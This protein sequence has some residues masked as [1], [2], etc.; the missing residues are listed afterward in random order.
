MKE[1]LDPLFAGIGG[2]MCLLAL[3]WLAWGA[4]I[5]KDGGDNDD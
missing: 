2:T 4:D 3:L 5:Y 1:T